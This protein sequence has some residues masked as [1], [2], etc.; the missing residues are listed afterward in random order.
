MRFRGGPA[1]LA[2]ILLLGGSPAWAEDC[3][4]TSRDDV[5]AAMEKAPSCSRAMQIASACSSGATGDVGLTDAVEARCEGDF[6]GRFDARQK[7][8]YQREKDACD[9]KYSRHEGTMYI[10]FAAFCRAKVA[11]RYSQ[12]ASKQAGP[13]KAR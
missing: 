10:S 7:R 9:R 8:T 13:S 6:L 5:I 1:I 2:V 4:A 12:K 3:P 11:Q